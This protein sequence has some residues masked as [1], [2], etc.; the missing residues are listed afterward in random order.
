MKKNC[1]YIDSYIF[2]KNKFCFLNSIW[3]LLKNNFVEIVF[4]IIKFL[5]SLQPEYKS[6]YR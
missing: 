4:I 5:L 1:V 6:E 3:I 2:M